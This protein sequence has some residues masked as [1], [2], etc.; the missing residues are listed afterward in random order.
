MTSS[1]VTPLILKGAL[2]SIGLSRVPTLVLFQ[3]NPESI[4]RN[5]MPRRAM[6]KGWDAESGNPAESLGFAGPPYETISFTLVLDATDGLEVKNKVA[7]TTGI[8]PGLSALEMLISPSKA[9]SL[10][11]EGL[12]KA[13]VI[14]AVPDSPPLT[15]LFLGPARV[16]PVRIDSLAVTEEAFDPNLNPF[17]ASVAVSLTVLGPD[18]VEDSGL[19]YLWAVNYS[20]VVKEALALVATGQAAGRIDS[21]IQEAISRF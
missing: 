1:P 4:T 15:L 12:K 18:D 10:A 8:L 14:S 20:T 2:V 9:G 11:T 6:S 13:G 16:L 5:L 3:Y 7:V 19:P 17:R 21:T